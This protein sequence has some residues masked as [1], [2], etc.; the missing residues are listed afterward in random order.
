MAPMLSCSG[1]KKSAPE[2]LFFDISLAQW[3]LHQMMFAG[4]LKNI[5][6]PQYTKQE[7]DIHAVEY[8]NQFFKDKAEDKE[9]LQ[10]L[11]NRSEGEGVKNLLIMIDGEGELGNSDEAARQTAVENHYKWIEAAKFLGCHSIRVNAAG[12]EDREALKSRVVQSLH[13]LCV[14]ATDYGI[15]VIV[16]NHGGLSSDGDWLADTIK[17]VGMDNCGTL[18]DFGNFTIDREKNITFDRYDGMKKLMPYAK[19]VSAKCYDFNPDGTESTIDFK[20]MLNI[21]KSA[22]F[23]GYIGI[24]FEGK[25][26]SEPEG[27]RAAKRLLLKTGKEIV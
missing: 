1:K 8:V 22:G 23:A 24:E 19:G 11:K 21:I 7:F 27:I 26:I 9:Y 13:E 25:G 10:E 4:E 6:F 17:T 20:N 2:S 18:P 14:F 5:D 3:S 12:E 16:E 15:N